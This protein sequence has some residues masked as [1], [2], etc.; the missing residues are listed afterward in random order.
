MD[1]W[2]QGAKI[3][4]TIYTWDMDKYHQRKADYKWSDDICKHAGVP[5]NGLTANTVVLA[6]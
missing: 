3:K 4:H 6:A 2:V 5:G 1:K